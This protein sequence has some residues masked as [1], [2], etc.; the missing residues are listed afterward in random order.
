MAVRHPHLEAAWPSPNAHA[1]AVDA[2]NLSPDAHTLATTSDDGT[3]HLWD[4]PSGRSIG[5]A[6]PGPAQRDAA[7][8]F[9]DAGNRLVTLFNNG[10][11]Y[12]WD[13]RPQSWASRACQVARRT[14]TR[15]EWNDVMPERKYAPACAAR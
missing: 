7:S 5:A 11:G 4:F 8:A 9:V 6:L 13:I 3:T 2:V 10:S 14:L 15:T 1:G 12:L